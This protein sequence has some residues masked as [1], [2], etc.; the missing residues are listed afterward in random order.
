[1]P[2]YHTPPEFKSHSPVR[3][4]GDGRISP[5]GREVDSTN[6]RGGKNAN[7]EKNN[8]SH[9][10]DVS[11]NLTKSNIIGNIYG[12][13]MGMSQTIEVADTVT[14]YSEGSRWWEKPSYYP[15]GW[16]LPIT[17]YPVYEEDTGY[18][19]IG[20]YAVM[21]II[22][23]INA[24]QSYYHK[25][26]TVFNTAYVIGIFSLSFIFIKQPAIGVFSIISGVI[27]LFKSLK[28]NFQ[29]YVVKS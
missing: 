24:I 17:S 3:G 23:V 14:T 29:I 4:R 27:V 9:G 2:V 16:N 8:S 21:G 11:I 26:D 18:V 20:M 5:N 1:M 12:S 13:G 22:A 28:E 7:S 15:N 19:L 25:S 10:G 6:G